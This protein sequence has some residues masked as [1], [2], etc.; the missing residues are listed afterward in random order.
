MGL[1]SVLLLLWSVFQ[2]RADIIVAKRFHPFSMDATSGPREEARVFSSDGENISF[3]HCP[4]ALKSLLSKDD[5]TGTEY[6]LGKKDSVY[7]EL[8]MK[9]SGVLPSRPQKGDPQ[10][11]ERARLVASEVIQLMEGQNQRIV[12][13]RTGFKNLTLA[14]P[15]L[16]SQISV[17]EV[18]EATRLLVGLKVSFPDKGNDGQLI[19]ESFGQCRIVSSC[20][21]S[22]LG[23]LA[24][25]HCD[26]LPTGKEA[27]ECTLRVIADHSSQADVRNR[28]LRKNNCSIHLEI[29]FLSGFRYVWSHYAT[30]SDTQTVPISD[31][32]WNRPYDSCLSKVAEEK[33]K[34]PGVDDSDRSPKEGPEKPRTSLPKR[35]KSSRL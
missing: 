28:I 31:D 1:L 32:D 7:A 23:P 5:C 25:H 15:P 8:V 11:L 33:T 13:D 35:L 10:R 21:P 19:G 26:E 4:F 20:S 16:K 34:S 12:S 2:S 24:F 14:E 17:E 30:F 27:K 3:R 22:P 9:L 18:E 29:P 6:F